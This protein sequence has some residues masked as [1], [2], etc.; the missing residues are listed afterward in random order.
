[1]PRKLAAASRRSPARAGRSRCPSR[2]R[3]S[4]ASLARP[5]SP[6]A[7]H[8][9]RSPGRHGSRADGRGR[10]RRCGPATG[11]RGRH[12]SRCRGLRARGTAPARCD[13]SRSRTAM[14]PG[15]APTGDRGPVRQ[16]GP[17]LP[18][19]AAPAR[20]PPAAG[21]RPGRVPR[22]LRHSR[23]AVADRPAARDTENRPSIEPASKSSATG[24]APSQRLHQ[25]P[26]ATA[27][28]AAS[29][30]GPPPLWQQGTART[31]AKQQRSL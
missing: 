31:G 12:S 29:S 13:P 10:L 25:C 23:P 20:F 8:R 21:R 4:A 30:A 18:P 9:A 15:S 14:G 7:S 5:G 11:V 27:V 6:G 17:A 22:R 1:M 26:A 19:T 28:P 16:G 3:R 2:A 24:G